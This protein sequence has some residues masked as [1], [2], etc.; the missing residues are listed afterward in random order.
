MT[1]VELHFDVAPE[2]AF[3]VL[4]EPRAYGFWVVGARGV[5]EAD[6]RWP[7]PGATFRHSQGRWPLVLSD[8]SSVI[9]ADP[10]RR[11]ELEARV[12]PL[13]VSRVVFTLEPEDGRTFVRMQEEATGGLL[14]P[15]T[16]V[17]PAPQL[18]E[19]RNLEAL[20]RLRWIAE[21]RA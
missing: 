13:L 8:T 5:H 2:D 14:E 20:R 16:R 10:P 9:A 18:L 7:A 6:P 19:A 12:R 4:A 17:P 1:I 3:A 15:A 11:L 21:A